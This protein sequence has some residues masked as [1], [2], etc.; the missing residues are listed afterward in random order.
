MNLLEL[1]LSKEPDN[2]VLAKRILGDDF[3]EFIRDNAAELCIKLFVYNNG[4]YYLFVDM[5]C[6]KVIF[7]TEITV[8]IECFNLFLV[9]TIGVAKNNEELITYLKIGLLTIYNGCLN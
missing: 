4:A 6:I 8:S 2:I 3:D 7:G 5:E 1:L 9:F